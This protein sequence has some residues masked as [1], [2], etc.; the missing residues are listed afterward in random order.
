MM[1]LVRPHGSHETNAGLLYHPR[2]VL[3]AIDNL[4]ART[5]RRLALFFVPHTHFLFLISCTKGEH[6]DGWGGGGFATYITLSTRMARA[7]ACVWVIIE[8]Q[9]ALHE[10]HKG[11]QQ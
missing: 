1:N 3:P 11:D 7:L 2:M 6:R 9:P 8:V 5:R 4:T 10:S